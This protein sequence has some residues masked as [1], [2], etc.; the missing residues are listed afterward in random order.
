MAVE[1]AEGVRLFDAGVEAL[2]CLAIPVTENTAHHVDL[3]RMAAQVEEAAQVPEQMDVELIPSSRRMT[4]QMPSARIR[5]TLAVPSDLG[6]RN[7]GARPRHWGSIKW[8]RYLA[9]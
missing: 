6:N 8:F 1:H 3:A 4:R 9:R 2:G 5:P 7:L